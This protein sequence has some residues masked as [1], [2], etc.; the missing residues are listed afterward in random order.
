VRS[1]ALV[2]VVALGLVASA[3]GDSF[4]PGQDDDDSAAAT[5][6]CE[7]EGGGLELT[8]SGALSG[9]I[10]FEEPACVSTDSAWTA[11]W[12]GADAWVLTLEA[13]SPVEGE[14]LTEGV[15]VQLT[16]G[17]TVYG[18][19]DGLNT[20]D[21]QRY[22]PPSAPCGLWTVNALDD[23]AGAFITVA[24]QPAPLRCD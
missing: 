9:V 2:A 6:L 14:L 24:P 3:C 18:S 8:F 11:T 1:L 20:L 17:V 15:V 23:G 13:A 5:A 12:P 4:T 19:D 22:E 16:D 7:A 10:S 21:V